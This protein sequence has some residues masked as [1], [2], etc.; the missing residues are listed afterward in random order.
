[1]AKASKPRAGNKTQTKTQSKTRKKTKRM[2]RKEQEFERV[3]ARA[4]SAHVA[5]V[6]KYPEKHPTLHGLHV[7]DVALLGLATLALI[8]TAAANLTG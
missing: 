3:F 2:S 8:I 7:Y 4:T 1:M 6:Y 5:P